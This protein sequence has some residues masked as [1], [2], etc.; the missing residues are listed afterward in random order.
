MRKSTSCFGVS[1]GRRRRLRWN[2]EHYWPVELRQSA[3][4]FGVGG[5]FGMRKSLRR[6]GEGRDFSDLRCDSVWVNN[7]VMNVEAS[8]EARP[9]GGNKGKSWDDGVFSGV[10]QVNI[11]LDCSSEYLVGM[12]GFYGPIEENGGFEAIRLF[13][14]IFSVDSSFHWLGGHTHSQ[15]GAAIA[16]IRYSNEETTVVTQALAVMLNSISTLTV[17]ALLVTTIVHAF[18]FRNLFPNDIAI[19]ISKTKKKHHHHHNLPK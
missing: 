1:A 14:S 2:E 12:M 10:E 13:E 19:A 3:S 17:T 4:C 8:R 18:V 11:K 5:A 6:E 7:V 16:T 9:W 15:T